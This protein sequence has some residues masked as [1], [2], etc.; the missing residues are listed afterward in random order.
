MSELSTTGRSR[1]QTSF[2]G[3]TLMPNKNYTKLVLP[4]GFWR[5][6]VHNM[7]EPEAFRICNKSH[8]ARIVHNVSSKNRTAIAERAVQLAISHP[9]HC[10]AAQ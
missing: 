5:S 6:L 10:Q 1:V 8:S 2:K 3:W 9:S 4:S 7:E